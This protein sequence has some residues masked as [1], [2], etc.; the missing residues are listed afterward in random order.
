VGV[1]ANGN[2]LL[3]SGLSGDGQTVPFSYTVTLPAGSTVV[4]SAQGG[5]PVTGLTAAITGPLIT[6]IPYYFS[7]IAV[8]GG[9]QTTLTF[10]NYSPQQI[11]QRYKFL[12]RH[13]KPIVGPVQ[14]RSGFNPHRYAPGWTIYP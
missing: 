1:V 9:F 3:S 10:I 6:Q 12:F 4:F 13:R 2:L 14:R 11:T 7:Q 8:G 5:N